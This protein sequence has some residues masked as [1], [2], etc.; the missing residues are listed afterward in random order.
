[1][2]RKLAAYPLF[3]KDPYFS[4]WAREEELIGNNP[5]FWV[6]DSEKPMRGY[7]VCDGVEYTFLGK[8]EKKLE[9]QY[10]KT[11]ACITE[12]FFTG[13]SFDLKLEFVFPLAPEQL[14]LTS[15]PVCYLKYT[16][17]PKKPL[18]DAVIRFEIDET[19]CYNT[20][21]KQDRREVT[22][23]TVVDYGKF[24]DAYVGLY[25]QLVF[26]N[27]VDTVGADWGYYHLTGEK[28]EVKKENE[29]TVICAENALKENGFFML[30]FDDV[31]SINYVGRP[32]V[33]YYFKDGKE[34]SDALY[35]SFDNAQRVFDFCYKQRETLQKE[36]SV[37]GEEYLT[38]CNAA[39]AQTIAAHKL[40][41]DDRTNKTLFFSKECGSCGC[42]ATLDVTYPSAP[43]FLRY[44]PELVRGMLYPIFEFA[45]KRVWTYDF[46]PHDTGVYPL[47]FGQYYAFIQEGPTKYNNGAISWLKKETLTMPKIYDFPVNRDLYNFEKQM[48]VEESANVLVLAYAAY[49]ADGDTKMLKDEYKL[50]KLWADY[51]VKNGKCPENQ[52]TTDDFL[53]RKAK[54]INLTIKAVVGLYAFS[55]IAKINGEDGT[56]YLD[57]AKDFAKFTEDYSKNMKHMPSTFDLTDDTFSLKYNM[58]FDLWFGS[59]LFAPETYQK[60]ANCYLNHLE[61]YGV[62]LYSDN[63]A[64]KT[65]WMAFVACFS[66]DEEYRNKLYSSI[67]CAMRETPDRVPFTDWY[68]ITNAKPYESRFRNRTVQGGMFMPLLIGK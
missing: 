38:I 34:M 44:N 51:L 20:E 16:V 50:L 59:N 43:L 47:C 28:C 61:K 30:G 14:E 57:A 48:P 9:Q 66:K 49:K 1:M 23:A 46:A 41:H 25:R 13:E 22:S 26:S 62:R 64:V 65:D 8:G 6:G 37:H 31:V 3:I 52:L 54:A 18:K 29:R 67:T 58:A 4:I 7:I 2:E 60:E 21:R 68:D 12:C 24:E 63:I 5:V 35:D 40:V 56:K 45:K 15:C 36:W 11:E 10:I 19:I 27:S 39:Y 42:M 33:G 32:L 53:G 17:T 55:E